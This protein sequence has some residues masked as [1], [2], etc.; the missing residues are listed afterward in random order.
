MVVGLFAVVVLGGAV[1]AFGA[2]FGPIFYMLNKERNAL[3]EGWEEYLR[4]A[5]GG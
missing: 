3:G 5:R 4:K 1:V 2:L